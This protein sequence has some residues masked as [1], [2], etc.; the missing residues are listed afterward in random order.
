M[1]TMT[2]DEL[3]SKTIDFLRFP[4]AVMVMFIHIPVVFDMASVDYFLPTCIE[5]CNMTKIS[6]SHVVAQA[7]VPCFFMFSGF[8]FFYKLPDGNAFSIYLSKLKRRIR[9]LLVPYFLWTLIAVLFMALM[10]GLGGKENV[11]QFF[12]DLGDNGKRGGIT[13]LLWGSSGHFIINITGQVMPVYSPYM[14]SLWFVRDLMIMVLLSPLVYLFL[15]H[16]RFYGILLLGILYYLKIGFVLGRFSSGMFMT[17]VFFFCLGAYFS[18]EKKNMI[19]SLRKRKYLWL[20]LAVTGGLASAYF[21]GRGC[22]IHSIS[23]EMAIIDMQNYFLPVYTI[24][25]VITI[26]NIGSY[27]IE[28]QKATLRPLLSESSFFVYVAHPLLLP[29]IGKL[30]GRITPSDNCGMTL[31]VYFLSPLLCASLLF[32]AYCLLKRFVPALSGLLTGR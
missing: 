6:I 3:Q 5:L 28:R 10:A 24:S 27:L 11:M 4:L 7:A 1:Q 19:L 16:T 31:A 14:V 32:C 21:D 13:G 23:G 8:L 20:L 29:V 2:G 30:L 22:K 26:I 12:S 9:T 17:A 25:G 15:K 18:I